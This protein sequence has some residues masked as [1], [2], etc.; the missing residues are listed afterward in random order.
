MAA[1][2]APRHPIATS[3]TLTGLANGVHT[4]DVIGKNDAGYY[5]NDPAFRHDRAASPARRG[6][7]IRVTVPRLRR[8]GVRINEVLALNSETQNFGTGLF[9]DIIELHN[10]GTATT[11]PRRAGA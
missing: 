5:Q 10:A 6:P 9:P 3:I 11:G 2:G 1:R 4:V 8:S 7:S